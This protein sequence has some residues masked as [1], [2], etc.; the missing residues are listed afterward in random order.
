MTSKVILAFLLNNGVIDHINGEQK[1]YK[2]LV[3]ELEGA[4]GVKFEHN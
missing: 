3:E 1:V 2:Q 4:Y